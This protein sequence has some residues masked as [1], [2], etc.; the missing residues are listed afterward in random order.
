MGKKSSLELAKE[1]ALIKKRAKLLKTNN[2]VKIDLRKRISHQKATAINKKWN[3]WSKFLN[4]DKFVKRHVSS[5]TAKILKKSGYKTLKNTVFIQTEGYKNISIKNNQIL[6][7]TQEKTIRVLPLKGHSII[8]ELE[9]RLN[10]PLPHNTYITVRIGDNSRF[11]VAY[12]KIGDLLNYLNAW[13]PKDKA[14]GPARDELKSELITK[15]SVVT[16]NQFGE[17]PQNEKTIKP[18]KRARRRRH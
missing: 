3:E 10:K 15:M 1:K 17:S 14:P 5:K 13:E 12:D 11:N 7:K 6:Y 18:K 8:K 16:F 9:T 4:K 2:I